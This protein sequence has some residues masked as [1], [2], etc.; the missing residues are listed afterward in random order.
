MICGAPSITAWVR[1]LQQTPFLARLCGRSGKVSDVGTVYGFLDRPI[2]TGRAV[3]PSSGARP[4]GRGRSGRARRCPRSAPG[5]PTGWP[6][7]S[8]G[9]PP[10]QRGSGSRT[11][12]TRSWRPSSTRVSRAAY[13]PPPATW[14]WTGLRWRVVRT[15][16]ARKCAPAPASFVGA[17]AGSVTPM[18]RPGCDSELVLRRLAQKSRPYHITRCQESISTLLSGQSGSD[19]VPRA[20]SRSEDYSYLC[21]LTSSST[22]WF[23][24]TKCW[25]RVRWQRVRLQ[26]D[27]PGLWYR[28]CHDI[29]RV[30]E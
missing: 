8:P 9:K 20:S 14:R 15:R 3:T 24:P 30:L 19:P 7:A 22:C 5:P 28:R 25:R 26:R 12:G 27:H 18:P 21:R 4:G 17:C 23:C 10:A 2:R 16:S 6:A 11:R 13:R 29:L 1:R